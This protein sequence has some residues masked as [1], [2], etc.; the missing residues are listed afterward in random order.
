M[1]RS[2]ASSVLFAAG[3]ALVATPTHAQSTPADSQ[4]TSAQATAPTPPSPP[5]DTIARSSEAPPRAATESSGRAGRGAFGPVAAPSQGEFERYARTPDPTGYQYYA[6]PGA[7]TLRA[8]DGAVAVGTLLGWVAVRYGAHRRI[9]VGVGVPYALVGLSADVRFNIVSESNVAF[10]LWAMVQI[11]MHPGTTVASDFFGFTWNGGGAWGA[12]GPV[13][14]V[15]GDRGGLH[16]GAHAAQRVSMGGLWT[17]AHLTVDARI[18][19]GVKALG[20]IF[21]FGEA[22]PERASTTSRLT[23]LGNA[24]PRWMPYGTLGV[25]LFTRKSSVD[26]GALVIVGERSLLAWGTSPVSVW[27][28]LSAVHSF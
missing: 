8:G 17:L 24:Q 22:I 2:T 18:V 1:R 5:S 12:V 4:A 20:Q 13:F 3:F 26:V 14:S 11:P 28:W 7:R 9:D 10:G 15:W 27:P 21:V 19:D 23:L 25:R 16:I 6:M